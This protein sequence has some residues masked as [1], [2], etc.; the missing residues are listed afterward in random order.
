MVLCVPS[1]PSL[2]RVLLLIPL[3]GAPCRGRAGRLGVLGPLSMGLV[4]RGESWCMQQGLGFEAN[5]PCF[6]LNWC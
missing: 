2:P 6:L 3:R 5:G 4:R 1:I